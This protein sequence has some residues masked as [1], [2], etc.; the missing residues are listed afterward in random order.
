[1]HAAVGRLRRFLKGNMIEIIKLTK[2][3]VIISKP[4][5]VAAQPDPSGDEDA[6]TLT[7]RM[8]SELGEKS[9]LFPI[10]RLDRVV[11]GL[12]VF[13]RER[14]WAATL[15]E[16]VSGRGLEKEYFAVVEGDAEGGVMRDLLYKDSKAGKAYVVSGE[17]RAAKPAELEYMR[18][19]SVPSERGVRTLVRIKL[20]TGRFHQIRA[21][22]SSRGM[23]LVGDGKYG[24]RDNKAKM[25]A[26]FATRLAFTVGKEV[27]DVFALPDTDSYPWSLF[28][29]ENYK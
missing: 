7:S 20:H 29:K 19:A 8:L 17:R 26:L 24:S 11:G 2:G 28:D 10:H 25:P 9:E 12:L 27:C 15:S 14:R 21:Q 23:P 16:L 3:Y 22:F 1:M 13:A 5:G 4:A 6:M 18:V